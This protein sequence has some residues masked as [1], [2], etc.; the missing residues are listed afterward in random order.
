MHRHF[1]A[2]CLAFGFT[3]VLVAP[4]AAGDD[5]EALREEVR[6]LRE[7]VDALQTQ[8]TAQLQGEIEDYLEA[9]AAWE[10]AAGAPTWDRISIHARF[11][12]VNQNTL[13]LDPADRAVVSGDVDLDFDFQV[14]DNLI[15]FLRMTAND[16][17][18]EDDNGA[19][20]A[21]F[22]TVTTGSPPQTFG[23]IGGRTFSGFMDAIGVNGT[24]PTAPGSV[25]MYEAGIQWQIPI[26]DMLLHVE[27][28]ALDPRTRF[29]QNAFAKDP[30]TQFINNL[31]GD[32]AGI[33]WLTDASGRTSYGAHLWM[34]FGRDKQFTVN[35]GWFNTPGQFFNQGQFYAQGRWRGEVNG[36][37]MNLYVMFYVQE[38]F[39]DV[40]GDGDWGG[41]ASWDWLVTDKIGVWLRITANSG[42]VNPMQADYSFGVQ[43]NGPLGSRPDD[44]VG[45]AVGFI[46][47]NDQVVVG[48]PKDT[49]T[50]LE[51]YYRYMLEDGKLQIS[52]HLMFVFDPGG[53][54][55]PWQDDT[56]II[57][58]VRIFVPF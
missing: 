35:M 21:Q 1:T 34:S 26:R 8:Q 24:V 43:L 28:G 7:Q 37:E 44:K 10:G 32:P 49:E 3:A 19:F 15:L 57:L 36:R 5:T 48:V 29:L 38:Y 9:S 52:P 11:T 45:V 16:S 14:T 56:L 58:G 42:D 18:G 25:R 20:P 51:I 31:F 39:Q 22:G 47:A 53:N 40:D 13:G 54:T 4:A 2:F 23:P 30:N 27:L 55:S 33:P 6:Q 46:Q 50:T 41:G 12:A 17:Q